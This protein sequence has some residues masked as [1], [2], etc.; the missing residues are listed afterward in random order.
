MNKN[1]SNLC[2]W[3]W[4]IMSHR[5]RFS[6]EAIHSATHVSTHARTD[7]YSA[8]II[9]ILEHLFIV[10]GWLSVYTSLCRFCTCCFIVFPVVNWLSF[11]I[12]SFTNIDAQLNCYNK[13]YPSR[14]DQL[15]S[16]CVMQVNWLAWWFEALCKLEPLHLFTWVMNKFICSDEKIY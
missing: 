14:M 12:L 16:E 13:I 9:I 5:N 3:C 8:P 2:K 1:C 11:W 15:E 10:G 6:I 7:E 4:R